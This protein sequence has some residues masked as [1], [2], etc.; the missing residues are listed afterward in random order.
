[1]PLDLAGRQAKVTQGRWHQIA[2]MLDGK[3]KRTFSAL[4]RDWMRIVGRQEREGENQE[5][6]GR[7]GCVSAHMF[8]WCTRLASLLNGFSSCLLPTR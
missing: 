4:A 2:G 3:Q 5:Q 8:T 6:A 7:T 1:M